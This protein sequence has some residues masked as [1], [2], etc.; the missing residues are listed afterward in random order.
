MLNTTIREKLSTA[1]PLVSLA[2][3]AVLGAACGQV[4]V[5]TQQNDV[6]RSEARELVRVN[7]QRW[8]GDEDS[9]QAA[10]VIVAYRTNGP[11]NE[12]MQN[13]GYRN[14]HWEKSIGLSPS[15]IDDGTWATNWLAPTGM[16]LF[17]DDLAIQA[18]S[19]ALEARMNNGQ[20]AAVENAAGLG[21]IEK[22]PSPREDDIESISNPDGLEELNERWVSALR[23]VTAELHSRDAYL[24]C[25]DRLGVPGHTPGASGSALDDFREKI[26]QLAPDWRVIANVKS[27]SQSEGWQEVLAAEAEFMDSDEECRRDIIASYLPEVARISTAFTE[28]HKDEIEALSLY[29]KSLEIEASSLGWAPDAPFGKQ[30]EVLLLNPMDGVDE[31]N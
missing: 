28:D 6:P 23:P 3:V 8:A 12:C 18:N 24:A 5:A 21:C 10:K 19:V 29:W 15:Y 7:F 27:R 25:L 26:N 14:Y 11:Y 30:T 9:S 4:N 16:R 2:C 1:G 31:A 22:N 20:L 17:S 13:L